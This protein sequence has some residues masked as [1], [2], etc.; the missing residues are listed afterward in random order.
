MLVPGSVQIKM[1]SPRLRIAESRKNS[2]LSALDVGRAET[3]VKMLA[4]TGVERSYASAIG[5][6]MQNLTIQA[7]V[8]AAM[9]SML[10]D[11][12]AWEWAN[13]EE[14]L[15]KELEHA[16]AQIQALKQSEKDLLEVRRA[17]GRQVARVC[18]M[19]EVGTLP[20]HRVPVYLLVYSKL[21]TRP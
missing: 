21:I 20:F 7:E 17:P 15:K 8:G 9:E 14:T 4:L 16:R 11:L 19:W 18:C 1:L 6:T 3:L 13:K 10:G 12:E 2:R 5:Q